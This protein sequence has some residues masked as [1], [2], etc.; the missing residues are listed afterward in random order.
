MRYHRKRYHVA[1]VRRLRPV[2]VH[3]DNKLVVEKFGHVRL[4]HKIRTDSMGECIL[5]C[6]FTASIYYRA[7]IIPDWH[8]LTLRYGMD[9]NTMVGVD[10]E[11]ERIHSRFFLLRGAQLTALSPLTT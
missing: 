11:H 3:R 6:V 1:V 7:T 2:D 10:T 4:A 8:D 5:D 9:S